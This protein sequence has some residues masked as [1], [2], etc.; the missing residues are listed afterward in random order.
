M[1]RTKKSSKG[2]GY[3][4]WGKRKGKMDGHGPDVKKSTHSKERGK[5]KTLIANIKK[6]K[7]E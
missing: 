7:E 3:E 4:F 5:T 6:G 1:S 2:P